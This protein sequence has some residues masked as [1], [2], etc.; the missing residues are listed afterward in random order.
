ML[1]VVKRLALRVKLNC[2]H[3][4]NKKGQR[5]DKRAVCD[6]FGLHKFRNTFAS[7]HHEAGVSVRTI[8]R[9]LR[10]SD[11]ETTPR[12]LAAADDRSEKTRGLVNSTFAEIGGAQ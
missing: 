12:Y 3:C 9:W 11:L 5:C 2:G 8:Q 10:H 4:T 7:M 6:R 1:R